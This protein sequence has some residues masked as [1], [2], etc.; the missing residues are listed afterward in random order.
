MAWSLNDKSPL[1]HLEQ[2]SGHDTFNTET[3][4]RP[5]AG[6]GR[7]QPRSGDESQ[8]GKSSRRRMACQSCR[9]RKVKCDGL[10]PSCGF[11]VSAGNQ[12]VYLDNPDQKGRYG[13]S[14]VGAL[15][16][17]AKLTRIG[18]IRRQRC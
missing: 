17:L 6:A 11:C 7:K 9:V 14:V 12:C 16:S 4:S 13:Y 1:E 15:S 2:H 10:R 8:M 18:W 3:T 5:A